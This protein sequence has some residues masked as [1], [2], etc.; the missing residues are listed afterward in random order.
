MHACTARYVI[1]AQAR[2]P[3]R[4]RGRRTRHLTQTQ[5]DTP[6]HPHAQKM[7][8]A[9]ARLNRPALGTDPQRA[10]VAACLSAASPDPDPLE[11]MG[12]GQHR[13]RLIPGEATNSPCARVLRPRLTNNR[14]GEGECRGLRVADW[15][16]HALG[17]AVRVQAPP[18]YCFKCL[19]PPR[20]RAVSLGPPRI[21]E[22]G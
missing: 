6:R 22:R 3:A 8:R 10:I 9:P 16:G 21:P 12:Q 17:D 5:D 18:L 20:T 19:Q 2:P 15:H 4:F 14:T 1:A 11:C 13:G 7:S